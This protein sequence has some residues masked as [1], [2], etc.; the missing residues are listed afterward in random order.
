MQIIIVGSGKVGYT[1]A[2]QLVNEDHSVVVVDIEQAPLDN[3]SSSID[4][5]GILGNCISVNTLKSAD[6]DNS[7]LLIA[8]TGSDEQNL[9]C[10]LVARKANPKCRTI[11]RVRNPV[12]NEEI[13]FLKKELGI[14]L[15]INPELA[16]ANEIAKVFRFPSA[17]KIDTFAKGR[18]ELLHIKIDKNSPLT[19]KMLS[20]LRSDIKF[21]ILVCTVTRNNKVIIPGGDFTL[22]ENDKITIVSRKSDSIE[23]CKAIGMMKNRITTA[24]IAGGGK[25]SYYLAR[26]LIRSGIRTTIIEKSRDTCE[27][28]AELLPEATIIHGDATDKNLLLEEGLDTTEGFAALTDFDEENILISLYAKTVSDVKTVTKINRVNFTSVIES[29][30]LDSIIYPSII[31]SSHILRYVRSVDKAMNTNVEN[32]YKLDDGNAEAVEFTVKEKSAL[33]GKP[34][35]EIKFRPN[36]LICC[37]IR[38]EELIIP[39][40]SDTIEVGDSVIV[41]SE[42]H[43]SDTKDL[44]G[45]KR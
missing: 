20:D 2:E 26:S 22:A 42:D 31:T 25:I 44:L 30:D 5:M 45:G 16:A 6:I 24:M 11:A 28:L 9:L 34:I 14:D 43:I 3:T 12:Y 1:L 41:V 4:V 37:I 40:G 27:F 15:I 38:N 36:T 35:S 32:L 10:C 17:I 19:G 7:D 29:L 21:N 8:V 33:T 18:I 23:F 13:D 39:G